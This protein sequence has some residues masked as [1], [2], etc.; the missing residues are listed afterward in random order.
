MCFIC[1]CVCFFLAIWKIQQA[2]TNMDTL[3][4]SSFFKNIIIGIFDKLLML[5]RSLALS[6]C[7]YVRGKKRLLEM[8]WIGLHVH[9]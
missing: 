6:L 9:V 4:T 7:V 1:V 2:L 5:V 3:T 8:K